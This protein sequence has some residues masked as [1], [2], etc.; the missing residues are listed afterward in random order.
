MKFLLGASRVV[1]WINERFA[2][3]AACCVLL[4]GLISAGNAVSRYSFSLSSNAWLEIQWYLFGGIFMLGAAYTLKLN[5]HV[6]VDLVYGSLRPRARLWVDLGGH[7]LFLMPAVCILGWMCWSLFATSYAIGEV[8]S[9]AGGLPRW[10]AK[11]LMPFGFA[12]LALQGLSEIVKRVAML[13]GHLP[14]AVAYRKP[15]Q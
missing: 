7:V 5:E 9:N 6:R 11:F 13:T 14:P 4:A 8:S 15:L 12:L 10:P 3:L 1:D 2:R